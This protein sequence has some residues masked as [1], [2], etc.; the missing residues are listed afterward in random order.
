MM[1]VRAHVTKEFKIGDIVI[2]VKYDDKNRIIYRKYH[3]GFEELITYND[4]NKV[5]S[6]KCSDDESYD[7]NPP[8]DITSL[9]LLPDSECYKN[10]E[11]Y[12]ENYDWEISSNDEVVILHRSINMENCGI[13]EEWIECNIHANVIRY[14]DS[15]DNER[16]YDGIG[17]QYITP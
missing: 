8:V 7:Y 6:I 10:I 16:Y 14:H 3:N 13:Y 4:Y 12:D 5:T 15:A 17:N 2:V 9:D 1:D 11:E